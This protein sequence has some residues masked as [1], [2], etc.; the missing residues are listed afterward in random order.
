M[1]HH[2]VVQ[3]ALAEHVGNIFKKHLADGL[4]DRIEQNGLFVHDQVRVVGNALRNRIH[5][6]KHGEPPVVAA[7]P[8]DVLVYFSCVVHGRMPLSK[9]VA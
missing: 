7:Y 1:L 5:A 4:I 9:Y 6:F 3:L 8:G 2:D